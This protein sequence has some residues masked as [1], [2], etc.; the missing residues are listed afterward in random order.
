M[1]MFYKKGICKRGFVPFTSMILLGK[2]VF[3]VS[4][5]ENNYKLITDQ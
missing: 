1:K 4:L 2:C 3:P 5:F